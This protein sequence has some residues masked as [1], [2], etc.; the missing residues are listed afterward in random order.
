MTNLKIGKNY[1]IRY[2]TE[3]IDI[4]KEATEFGEL[5][6]LMY[7]DSSVV[8]KMLETIAPC[9]EPDRKKDFIRSCYLIRDTANEKLGI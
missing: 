4:A 2:L 9:V 3:T 1:Y 6:T 8:I 7:A 5:A